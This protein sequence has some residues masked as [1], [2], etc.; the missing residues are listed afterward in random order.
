MSK[1]KTKG[2][3]NPVQQKRVEK[4]GGRRALVVICVVLA[5]LIVGI[6]AFIGIRVWQKPKVHDHIYT[7][8]VCNICKE[9][10]G[11]EKYENGVCTVCGVSCVHEYEDGSHECKICGS[12][13]AHTYENGVCTVC[14]ENCSHAEYKDGACVEC[15]TACKHEYEEGSHE[16]KL[17]GFISDHE[18]AEGEHDCKICGKGV[19]HFYEVGGHTCV[20]CGSVSDHMYDEG[21]HVCKICS[22]VSAHDW[23]K[24]VCKLCA[25]QCEHERENDVCKICG[26]SLVEFTVTFNTNGGTEIAGVTV[27]DRF[28]VARPADPE[29]AEHRFEGWFT[30]ESCTVAY[31]FNAEIIG[32]LTLYAKWTQLTFYTVTLNLNGGEIVL[33]GET[34]SESKV[35]VRTEGGTTLNL[36]NEPTRTGYD[37]KGWFTN[38]KCTTEFDPETL[39]SKNFNLYALWSVHYYKV[40]FE[41]EESPQAN[42]TRHVRYGATVVA[43]SVTFAGHTFCGWYTREVAEEG[44]VP[45]ENQ[46]IKHV[47][48]VAYLCTFFDLDTPIMSDLTLYARWHMYAEGSHVC[49]TCGEVGDHTFENSVCTVCG[50]CET[51]DY[52]DGICTRCA[53]HEIRY[54]GLMEINDFIAAYPDFLINNAKAGETVTYD[55]GSELTVT[56]ADGVILKLTVTSIGVE[57]FNT[58]N[59]YGEPIDAVK[60]ENGW[61]F[62][63]PEEGGT[64][65]VILSGTVEQIL[66]EGYHTIEYVIED[67]S[68]SSGDPMSGYWFV[69]GPKYVKEGEIVMARIQ[70]TMNEG[71]AGFPTINEA[72]YS[73]ESTGINDRYLIE[74]NG[75]SI[76]LFFKVTS[77]ASV[78]IVLT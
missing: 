30:D 5:I 41:T 6:G 65:S 10:C 55:F 33:N 49:Q 19:N 12:F 66:P 15:G 75:N 67:L 8:G 63:M 52:S 44:T 9:L 78:K 62:V 40:T 13:G 23:E 24:G 27:T 77:D 72:N 20:I 64:I 32:D 70:W 68:S 42:T 46:Y 1:T 37:F 18:Y 74:E 26:M 35:P 16:C 22:E 59:G 60:G 28:T 61:S 71:G 36:E 25:L 53:T 57:R 34:L 56:K 39:V 21:G 14:G 51:H 48:G 50:I 29:K 47:D 3:R 69:D 31:D 4:K 54:F 43:P 76:V 11:H 17:C 2:K 45:D 58:D 73:Y 7:G 38:S